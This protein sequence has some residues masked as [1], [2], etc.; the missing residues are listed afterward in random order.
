MWGNWGMP[1]IEKKAQSFN[2]S[3]RGGRF[4]TVLHTFPTRSRVLAAALTS[5]VT[6]RLCVSPDSQ[7]K[8]S[9]A[10]AIFPPGSPAYS[11]WR[12]LISSI[13]LQHSWDPISTGR[14]SDWERANWEE[15][16]RWYGRIQMENGWKG[17]TCGDTVES[18]LGSTIL[19]FS[20]SQWSLPPSLTFMWVRIFCYQFVDGFF[21][22]YPKLRWMV[23]TFGKIPPFIVRLLWQVWCEEEGLGGERGW[24]E[25]ILIVGSGGRGWDRVD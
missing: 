16:D 14:H 2:F 8:L 3:E 9:V 22:T 23:C 20:F 19:H 17:S 13:L 18:G 10:T 21:F 6:E 15:R 1:S 4:Q 25:D 7:I 12:N 11:P 5:R 24:Q